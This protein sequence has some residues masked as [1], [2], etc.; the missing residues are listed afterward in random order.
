MKKNLAL[1][2]ILAL[3]ST[4]F[5]FGAGAEGLTGEIVISVGSDWVDESKAQ[6]KSFMDAVRAY[7]EANPGVKVTAQGASQQDIKESFQTAALAGGGPDVVIMDNSGHAIDLAAMG[8]LLPLNQFISDDELEATYQPGP[9]NSG[10][11]EGVYYSVPWYLDCCGLYC[12]T[13]YLE[14]CG[15]S[16]P[17]TWEDLDN[18][19]KVLKENGYGG[20]ITY[21]SAYAFY[22]FFYQNECPVIDTSGEMPEVV[23][24]NEAGTEAWNFICKLITEDNGLVESFK[25]A[26]SWDKVY[27]SFANGEATFLLGGDWCKSGINDVGTSVNYAI[28]DMVM[29]KTRATVLGGWT[30]NINVNTKYPELA[31]DFCRYM[32]S[33]ET[34]DILKATGKHSAQTSWDVPSGLS[35]ENQDL[36]VL[37]EQFPYTMARPSIIN[38]KTIDE[39]ITNAI[40]TVV[41]GQANA[42]DS[43]AAMAAE[44]RANIAANYDI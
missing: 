27:E 5:C 40:L 15:L 8:L 23:I 18:C 44:L 39:I 16:I 20:I 41:Y 28:T 26:T 9:L 31:Y 7:E 33:P 32:S 17:E 1:L 29:G 25:E 35:E 42:E 6:G 13:D 24:D 3:L 38:E 2:L 12:N 22:S 4:L 30:W 19:L 10:K 11:F 37:G 14:A 43:L 36:V 34:Y 21:K